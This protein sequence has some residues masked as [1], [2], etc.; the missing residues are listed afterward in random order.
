MSFNCRTLANEKAEPRVPTAPNGPKW[1][2]MAPNWG[3]GGGNDVKV[4]CVR[5]S[6]GTEWLP[7]VAGLST[8]TDLQCCAVLK[9]GRGGQ[10]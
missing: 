2:Q 4:N 3:R 1:P 8:L 10:D 6:Y 5:V 7:R 9:Q